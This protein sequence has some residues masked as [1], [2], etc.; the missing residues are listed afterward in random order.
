MK[1]RENLD[2][3]IAKHPEIYEAYERYGRA[4]HEQGGPLDERTRWLIKLAVSASQG[5]AKAQITH[6]AKARAAGCTGEEIEHAIL[7]IA[8]TAGFPRMMEAMERF[9]ETGD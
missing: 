7:L 1:I 8:P 9:R 3:M 5:L 6:M 4:V 2:A